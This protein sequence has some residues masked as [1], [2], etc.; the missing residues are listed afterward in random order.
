MSQSLFTQS[1]RHAWSGL[2]FVFRSER[3]FRIQVLVGSIVLLAALLLR[4][5]RVD[6]VM[7]SALVTLVLVLECLN[8]VI[9]QLID[10]MKPRL[11]LQAKIVKDVVAGAVLLASVG[12]A[13]AGLLIFLPYL[14]SIFSFS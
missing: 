11:H 4:V 6:A 7:L 8:T 10:F 1:I 2:V 9:E 5:E 13:L 12:A 3:N 14:R